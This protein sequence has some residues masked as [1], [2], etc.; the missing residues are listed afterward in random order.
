ML[1]EGET[2]WTKLSSSSDLPMGMR[3]GSAS[4]VL[5]NLVFVSGNNFSN[6]Y[7]VYLDDM[8]ISRWQ[9]FLLWL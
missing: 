4:T 8:F 6:L 7:E 5:D 3:A 1:R 2:K 9:K